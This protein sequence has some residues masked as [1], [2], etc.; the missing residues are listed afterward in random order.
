MNKKQST[1]IPDSLRLWVKFK[2]EHRR[3]VDKKT[4]EI[5]KTWTWTSNWL[6]NSFKKSHN[7]RF[8]GYQAIQWQFSL[9]RMNC[10]EIR[11]YDSSIK[12]G[13]ILYHWRQDLGQLLNDINFMSIQDEDRIKG[14]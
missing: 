6:Q 1:I 14:P 7:Q 8:S 5:R 3:A 11:V 9:I 12:D 2:P 10:M 4:G 13:P